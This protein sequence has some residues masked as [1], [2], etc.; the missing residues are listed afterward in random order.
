VAPDRHDLPYCAFRPRSGIGRALASVRKRREGGPDVPLRIGS[1]GLGVGV[2]AALGKPGDAIKV[3]ELNPAVT[4]LANRHFTFVR[5]SK[6]KVDIVHGDGRILL[7][8][9]LATAGPQNYDILVVDAFR[10]ASPPLHLMTAEA[11]DIYLKHLAPDGVLA[12]NFEQDTFEMAPLHRGLADRFGLH[13]GWFETP[14]DGPD[15]DDAVSWALY[16]RDPDFLTSPGVADGISPWRDKSDS[17][18]LWTDANANLMSIVSWNKIWQ[19]TE[20]DDAAADRDE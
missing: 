17:K 6:A 10:G 12:I 18:L 15:C 3:Y 16:T 8:R 9:E 19:A 2:L 13:V 11:F 4:E 7:E 20:P 14:Q 5:D 1:V